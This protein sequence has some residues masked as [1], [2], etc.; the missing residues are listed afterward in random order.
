MN[1]QEIEKNRVAHGWVSFWASIAGIGWIAFILIIGFC[2]DPH[3]PHRRGA[4]AS[5]LASMVL[6]CAC[7]Y[8]ASRS[9]ERSRG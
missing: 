8:Q 6:A 1:I 9:L 3:G 7:T 2:V 5:I 4:Q